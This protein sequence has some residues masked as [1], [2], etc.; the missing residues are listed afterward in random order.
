MIQPV[1]AANETRPTSTRWAVRLAP[2][3]LPCDSAGTVLAMQG[4]VTMESVSQP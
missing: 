1:V 2:H 3:V 4:P